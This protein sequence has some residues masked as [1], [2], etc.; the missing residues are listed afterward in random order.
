MAESVFDKMIEKINELDRMS[1]KTIDITYRID[2]DKLAEILAEKIN[3]EKRRYS[4]Y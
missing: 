4:T 3:K 2:A 1:G